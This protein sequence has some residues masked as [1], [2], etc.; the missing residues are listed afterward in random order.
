MRGSMA[1]RGVR[2][3][4][5]VPLGAELVEPI[6]AVDPRV[7]VMYAPGLLPPLRYP[8][9]HRGVDEFRRAPED[10][11]RWWEMIEAAQVLYGMPGDS[12]EGLREAVR[13]NPN[14]RRVQATSAGAG[15]QVQAAG[16]T[17][18]QRERVIVTGLSMRENERIAALFVENLRRYL[19][20]EDLHNRVDPELLY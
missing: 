1:G 15:E 4:I 16:L 10:E 8:N 20:G 6:R 17:R 7:E 14:L 2:V 13:R 18:E 5:A 9:D 19:R 12:P 11:R 3:A